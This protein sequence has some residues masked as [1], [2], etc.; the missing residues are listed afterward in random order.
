[1][2]TRYEVPDVEHGGN[3]LND[4]VAGAVTDQCQLRHVQHGEHLDAVVVER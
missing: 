2:P 3:D 4:V 1:M